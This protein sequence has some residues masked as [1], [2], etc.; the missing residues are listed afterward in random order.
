[1]NVRAFHGVHR[2]QSNVEIVRRLFERFEEGGIEAALE[3]MDEELVIEIPPELSAE[4][5]DYHGH[6][7]ARR[8][9]AG[10]DG[11][12]EDVR[13]EAIELIPAGERVIAHIRLSGR[14]VT[15]GLDVDLE[16]FV[17]H[18]LAGGRVTRMRPYA[19]RESAEA[20]AG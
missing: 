1:V 15:S 7:G 20:A 6:D 10:F 4:P 16:A 5:D 12:L 11:M 17:V 8:Y 9:F 2:I 18:E 13:Y 14:G 3:G 19:D